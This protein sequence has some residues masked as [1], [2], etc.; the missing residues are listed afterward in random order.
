MERGHKP[1]VYRFLTWSLV[2]QLS[3]REVRQKRYA[4][5]SACSPHVSFVA[6]A[7]LVGNILN[8]IGSVLRCASILLEEPG[9][10]MGARALCGFATAIAYCSLVLY[11]QVGP[12]PVTDKS[13]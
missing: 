2:E 13:N 10:L 7:F 11:L 9:I 1:M 4:S 6:A 12:Y 3:D 5:R 8:A